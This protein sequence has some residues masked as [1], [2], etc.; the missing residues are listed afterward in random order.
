MSAAAAAAVPVA[1]RLLVALATMTTTSA[2]TPAISRTVPDIVRPFCELLV[3]RAE[4]G[5][6]AEEL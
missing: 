4:S 2:G 6:R 3:Y 5:C 1:S